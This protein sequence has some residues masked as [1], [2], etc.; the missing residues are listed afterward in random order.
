ML[1]KHSNWNILLNQKFKTLNMGVYKVAKETMELYFK[2]ANVHI[3]DELTKRIH[4]Y[5]STKD[6]TV[7]QILNELL[8]LDDEREDQVYAIKRIIRIRRENAK[9]SEKQEL[10]LIDSNNLKIIIDEVKDLKKWMK[11]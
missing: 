8:M 9:L 4:H 2:N 3:N 6:K 10:E 11:E 5:L 1:I 7:D